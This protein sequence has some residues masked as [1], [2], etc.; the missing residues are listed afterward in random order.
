MKQELMFYAQTKEEA[1]EWVTAIQR[2]TGFRNISEYYEFSRTLG[3]GKFGEVKLA[4][5]RLTKA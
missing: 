5:D 3:Q 4:I 2:V 1:T